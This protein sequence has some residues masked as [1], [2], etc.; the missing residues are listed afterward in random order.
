MT[1]VSKR[2]SPKPAP[3]PRARP[4]VISTISEFKGILCP[5]VWSSRFAGHGNGS[6]VPTVNNN[7]PLR[8]RTVTSGDTLPHFYFH[9]TAGRISGD[10]G[11]GADVVFT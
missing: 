9:L 6:A 11:S 8:R 7:T 4:V 5:G 2:F 1:R 10:S 3:S